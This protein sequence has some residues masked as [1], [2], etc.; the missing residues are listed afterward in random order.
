MGGGGFG[1]IPDRGDADLEDE[2]EV[3]NTMSVVLRMDPEDRT[4]H[5]RD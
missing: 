4:Q 1:E 5:E 3:K 2:R